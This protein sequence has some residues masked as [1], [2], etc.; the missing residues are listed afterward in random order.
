MC[1]AIGRN[2]PLPLSSVCFIVY[3][4]KIHIWLK[5]AEAGRVYYIL[6][7][8]NLNLKNFINIK[9]HDEIYNIQ[10][11]GIRMQMVLGRG[12]KFLFVGDAFC[13][14]KICFFGWQNAIFLKT[15]IYHI[16]KKSCLF[17]SNYTLFH[18]LEALFIIKDAF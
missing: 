13:M 14:T 5:G 16:I 2:S 8:F 9:F 11:T 7:D 17:P 18:H 1:K 12:L 15:L 3:S 4:M 6:F 10:G